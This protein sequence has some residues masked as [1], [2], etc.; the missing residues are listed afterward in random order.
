MATTIQAV[1]VN[2][3]QRLFFLSKYFGNKMMIAENG[4]FNALG[5]LC[6]GYT[7]GFWNY[8]ELSNGGFYMAPCLDEKLELFVE[9]NGYK[10]VLSADAAGIVACL[11]VINQFCWKYKSEKMINHYYLL[12]DFAAEH[13]E[14]SEIYAAID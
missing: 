14:T 3:N 7:G 13:T 1:A 9:S 6:S 2:D 8:Y 12:R 5:K 4:I 10:G 11:Y